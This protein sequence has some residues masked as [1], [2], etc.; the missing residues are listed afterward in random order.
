MRVII[1]HN[2]I[3]LL[4]I[5]A[6]HAKCRKGLIT[7]HKFNGITTM[8]KHIEFDHFALLKKC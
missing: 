4:E 8:K 2:D 3:A 5:L 7:Y 1:Y 6:M